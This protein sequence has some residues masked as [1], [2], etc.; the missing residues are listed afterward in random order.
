MMKFFCHILS[1]LPQI[2]PACTCQTNRTRRLL[3]LQK[4]CQ[5]YLTLYV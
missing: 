3:F 4:I 5:K 2:R 1:I